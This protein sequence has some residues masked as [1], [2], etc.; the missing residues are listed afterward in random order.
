MHPH[1]AQA[2]ATELNTDSSETIE[3]TQS[4][5]LASQHKSKIRRPRSAGDI[6]ET[7][8]QCTTIAAVTSGGISTF[9]GGSSGQVPEVNGV[10]ASSAFSLSSS[11]SHT[12]GLPTG[13]SGVSNNQSETVLNNNN[14]DIS[15]SSGSSNNSG[16]ILSFFKFKSNNTKHL[17]KSAAHQQQHHDCGVVAGKCSAGSTPGTI[18]TNVNNNNKGTTDIRYT[19]F[20]LPYG[21]N[22]GPVNSPVGCSNVS[23]GSSSNVKPNNASTP[24]ASPAS[25]ALSSINRHKSKLCRSLDS[26][27][28]DSS[29][30]DA[31]SISHPA[32]EPTTIPANS[33]PFEESQ[34][35][36][37]P[38]TRTYAHPHKSPLP[39]HNRPTS[40]SGSSSTGNFLTNTVSS[41][42]RK[43]VNSVTPGSKNKNKSK[44]KVKSKSDNSLHRVNIDAANVSANNVLAAYTNNSGGNTGGVPRNASASTFTSYLDNHYQLES[45]NSSQR[46]LN[47]VQLGDHATIRL[48]WTG[49]QQ[50]NNL[51]SVSSTRTFIPN[52]HNNNFEFNS[53]SFPSN[54]AANS[55]RYV[56]CGSNILR[57]AVIPGVLSANCGPRG[58]SSSSICN[59]STNNQPFV[60]RRRSRSLERC[61]NFRVFPLNNGISNSGSTVSTS[62][63]IHH[64][65][66]PPHTLTWQDTESHSSGGSILSRSQ[67]RK[68]T[69]SEKERQRTRSA[70]SLERSTTHKVRQLLT[71]TEQEILLRNIDW[72]STNSVSH[73]QPEPPRR[74][75]KPSKVSGIFHVTST[76]TE[77]GRQ[78]KSSCREQQRRPFEKLHRS[79]PNSSFSN[80]SESGE[81]SYSAPPSPPPRPPSTLKPNS[82]LIIHHPSSLTASALRQH[83]QHQSTAGSLSPGSSGRSSMS[84]N[85]APKRR[86]VTTRSHGSSS[87]SGVSH[88]SGNTMRGTS[89]FSDESAGSVNISQ[90]SPSPIS[91]SVLSP[92]TT[93]PSGVSHPL[94]SSVAS[95]NLAASS[96]AP[97]AVAAAAGATGP[98]T[99]SA[100]AGISLE[101]VRNSGFINK[102]LKGWLHSD[103]ML[104]KEGVSYTVRVS[105]K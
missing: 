74:P 80:S 15:P 34:I 86:P 29:P 99:T 59:S 3:E 70:H 48:P 33:S 45:S 67:S 54:S 19:K 96:V 91:A 36:F 72:K 103:Q 12:N 73:P 66:Q 93:S 82:R 6:T 11:Q 53:S 2:N 104:S 47:S 105:A 26:S 79:A 7:L 8:H 32:G 21:R 10:V 100:P 85:P 94:T 40:S 102:P 37:T 101:D 41:I 20:P 78:R 24:S 39:Q 71:P 63:V 25:S 49:F 83:Q 14:I 51:S 69:G 13:R 38:Q 64:H 43:V 50:I 18:S 35:Q 60:P 75:D 68:E 89:D 1:T 17:E 30:S 77:N 81:S 5:L 97:I 22:T 52:T 57:A 23:G 98:T 9:P 46:R 62:N 44:L 31:S 58:T 76:H 42:G 95:N 87:D 65:P 56:E 55:E 92:S 27:T 61:S 16:G 90:H 84:M 4:E 88:I 28:A